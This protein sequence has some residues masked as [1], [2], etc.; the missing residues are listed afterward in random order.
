MTGTSFPWLPEETTQIGELIRDLNGVRAQ[1][2]AASDLSRAGEVQRAL[3]PK[4]SE[5][6]PGF[7]V[8]G[9]CI[10]SSTVGGDFYDWYS[11]E[12]GLAF[13]LGGVMG[14][15][16]GAGMIAAAVR[17]SLRTDRDNPDSNVAVAHASSILTADLA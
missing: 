10:P 9:A 4:D 17:T 16:V 3:Q 1:K 13:T 14:K 15:G 8:A 5:P 6:A 12:G 2:A 7:E 11:I